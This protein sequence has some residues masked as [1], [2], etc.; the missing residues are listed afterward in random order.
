MRWPG[1]HEDDRQAAKRLARTAIAE[2]ADM[3]LA[4]AVAGAVRAIL[5]RD[6][7]LA[8]AAIDRARM[9]NPNSAVVLAF[10]AL[11]SCICGAYDT[12]I[13]TPRRRCNSARWS[14]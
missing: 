3:P 14:R 9:L 13:N 12:A 1:G 2:G 5:T 11:T 4:L 10:A 7:D 8:V 6:H